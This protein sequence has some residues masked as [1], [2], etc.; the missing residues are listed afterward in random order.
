MEVWIARGRPAPVELALSLGLD[1][2]EAL[3]ELRRYRAN[4]AG[5]EASPQE[6]L[7]RAMRLAQQAGLLEEKPELPPKAVEALAKLAALLPLLEEGW[8]A[9]IQE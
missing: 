2:R 7:L 3:Q 4:L 8:H 9:L 1:P 5:K 6:V